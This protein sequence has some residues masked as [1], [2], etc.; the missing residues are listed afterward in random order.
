MS[1]TAVQREKQSVPKLG[2]CKTAAAASGGPAQAAPQPHVIRCFDGT[3]GMPLLPEVRPS[4]GGLSSLQ[5]QRAVS[6]VG[7][8]RLPAACDADQTEHPARHGATPQLAAQGG[9]SSGSGSGSG[10][11]RGAAGA[12]PAAPAAAAAASTR[13]RTPSH[14]SSFAPTSAHTPLPARPASSPQCCG[15]AAGAR[16][17]RRRRWRRWRAAL[18]P[19]LLPLLPRTAC[20]ACRGRPSC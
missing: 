9:G 10:S 1:G 13:R 2:S 18:P 5:Q 11:S 6:G 7:M 20:L 14:G 3:A 12:R 15:A 4:C 16:R 19:L 17:W 8:S